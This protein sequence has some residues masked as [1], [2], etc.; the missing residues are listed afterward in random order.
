[1]PTRIGHG[2]TFFQSISR[3]RA[4]SLTHDIFVE[5]KEAPMKSVLT[6]FLVTLCVMQSNAAT[7]KS[8]FYP[9][10]LVQDAGDAPKA[11]TCVAWP[12]LENNKVSMLPGQGWGSTRRQAAAEA[13]ANCL[14]RNSSLLSVCKVSKK[15]CSHQPNSK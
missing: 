10:L 5:I 14:S 6:L 2:F 13:I 15:D 8:K 11:F 12:S 7:K 9:V 4:S 3:N 1:M